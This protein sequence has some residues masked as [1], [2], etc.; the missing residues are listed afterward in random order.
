MS[1]WMNWALGRALRGGIAGATAPPCPGLYSMPERLDAALGGGDHGAAVARAQIDQV[2]VLGSPWPCRA[3]GRPG[4]R[5]VGTQTTSLP[6][7][8]T[9]GLGVAWQVLC[10][11]GRGAAG[12]RAWAKLTA[13]SQGAV[14]NAGLRVECALMGIFLAVSVWCGLTAGWLCSQISGAPAAARPRPTMRRVLRRKPRWE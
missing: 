3:C 10:G 8:P 5:G 9:R 13:S 6:A 4:R 14:E 7:W 1:P 11:R 2:V 12:C